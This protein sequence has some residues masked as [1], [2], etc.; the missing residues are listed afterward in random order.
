VSNR[1]R[2]RIRTGTLPPNPG[3][4]PGANLKS[5]SH[6]CRP[7]LVAFVW[8][9]T[10]ETI[11]LHLGCLQ[12]G[13][14]PQPRNPNP[15]TL[16]QSPR[17]LAY[18]L[19]ADLTYFFTLVTGPRRSLNLKLSDTKVYEPQIRARLGTTAHCCEAPRRDQNNPPV[20]GARRCDAAVR[21]ACLILT[22]LNPQPSTLNPEPWIIN[23]RP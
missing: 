9:L 19:P 17:S 10:K 21:I 20:L 22:T 7:I 1:G 2:P 14:A 23:P 4:N 13:L 18:P 15:H 11:Y 3:G 6:R 12:G 8:E 16:Q 5:I